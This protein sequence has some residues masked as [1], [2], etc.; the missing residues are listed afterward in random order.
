MEENQIWVLLRA[1]LIRPS[2]SDA[3]KEQVSQRM[4]RMQVVLAWFQRV[5]QQLSNHACR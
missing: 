2:V 1:A 4:G 3:E 5:L